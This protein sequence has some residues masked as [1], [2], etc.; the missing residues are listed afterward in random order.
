MARKRTVR[1]VVLFILGAMLIGVTGLAYRAFMVPW[2][3][4]VRE[5]IAA[6][7]FVGATYF[8][9][10]LVGLRWAEYRERGG[11]GDQQN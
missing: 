2:R 1:F 4:D 9:C 11:R 3:G 10:C 5:P 6:A 8:I 7:V